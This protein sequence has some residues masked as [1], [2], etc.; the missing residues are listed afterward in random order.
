MPSTPLSNTVLGR[1]WNLTMFI[2]ERIS[3]GRCRSILTRCRQQRPL[4]KAPQ[5]GRQ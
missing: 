5:A 4:A 1:L 2:L 3:Y